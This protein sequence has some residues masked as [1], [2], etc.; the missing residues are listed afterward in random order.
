MQ[1]RDP[2]GPPQTVQDC[3]TLPPLPTSSHYHDGIFSSISSC[4]LPTRV[5]GD[6]DDFI[7]ACGAD[8]D[9][10]LL[11]PR[12]RDREY[13]HD[14]PELVITSD[15]SS[16]ESDD[17]Y[18]LD[19][20]FIGS[21]V[22]TTPSD[23]AYRVEGALHMVFEYV[24]PDPA[25]A[26]RVLRV[27]T[28]PVS[29]ASTLPN[30]QPSTLSGNS[31]VRPSPPV[32]TVRADDTRAFVRHVFCG[33]KGGGLW[34]RPVRTPDLGCY[35]ANDPYSPIAGP[36]RLSQTQ[37]N[38]SASKPYASHEDA[39]DDARDCYLPSALTCTALQ[40]YVRPGSLVAV[41]PEFLDELAEQARPSRPEKRALVAG[42]IVRDQ[43]YA[44]MQPDLAKVFSP[45]SENPAGGEPGTRLPTSD[46]RTRKN[47]T[48]TGECTDSVPALP[49]FYGKRPR[50]SSQTGRTPSTVCVE[51]KPKAALTSVSRLVPVAV[52]DALDK[53]STLAYALKNYSTRKPASRTGSGYGGVEPPS[54]PTRAPRYSP[55]DLL[56]DDPARIARALD[57]LRLRR[58]H[59]LRVFF[60]G[61]VAL[62]DD[63]NVD[64]FDGDRD[65]AYVDPMCTKA[66]SAA[67]KVLAEERDAVF[68]V[69]DTQ[70]RDY[71]DA[72]G[73]EKIWNHLIDLLGGDEEASET[74]VWHAYF[75]EHYRPDIV[76]QVGVARRKLGYVDSA[77][78]RR[79]HSDEEVA[80]AEQFVET[81]SVEV[82]ARVIADYMVAGVTKDCSI[83]I[84][85]SMQ[86]ATYKPEV[87]EDVVVLDDDDNTVCVYKLHVVDLDPKPVSKIKAWADRDRA[88]LAK[89]TG[90]VTATV[91]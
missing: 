28:G 69:L 22:H 44:L 1:T 7:D 71:V 66:I 79:M 10:C 85:M 57:A 78:A 82:S 59:S 51:V 47:A 49:T 53:F 84:S 40:R 81:M 35:T 91:Y 62:A 80:K 33:G 31:Q 87:D 88:Q 77:Q 68:G 64:L 89:R 13:P 3:L 54:S 38:T 75:D 18:D 29:T 16:S 36:T 12:F 6:R 15:D 30:T 9:S 46:L 63:L 67:A 19:S 86:D 26:H 73:A 23:W 41:A 34:L 43:P 2:C 58:A 45:L 60:D 11:H 20:A 90:M 14:D 61:E 17:E 65:A 52:C 42:G 39:H 37:L 32:S 56:S 72:L 4:S 21:P 55:A 25:L 70:R 5:D 83:M 76:E 24:G 50:A 8:S 27:Q 48:R 74:A